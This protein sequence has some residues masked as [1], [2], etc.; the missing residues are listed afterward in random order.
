MSTHAAEKVRTSRVSSTSER[1]SSHGTST[2]P[3]AAA[4]RAS[5]GS[6][7]SHARHS[8]P[9][10]GYTPQHNAD[11]PAA[12]KGKGSDDKSAQ[13]TVDGWK[14]GRNDCLERV[15]QNQGYSLKEIYAKGADGK[16][17]MQSIA[18]QNGLSDPNKI[19]D[20]SK[21]NI[22]RKAGTVSAE[23][24]KPGQTVTR[25]AQD[26]SGTMAVTASRDPEHNAKTVQTD[27]KTAAPVQS[28]TTVQEGG[29]VNGT[30]SST[31][32]GLVSNV[33]GENKSGDATTDVK[34]VANGSG[35]ATTI[36]DSDARKNLSGMVDQ[37]GLY[38][39]NNGTG[40]GVETGLSHG[41]Q[42]KLESAGSWLDQHINPWG[43][44][45]DAPKEFTDASK[46]EHVKRPD[47]SISVSADGPEGRK[48]EWNREADG[49]FQRNLRA[50]NN[51]LFGG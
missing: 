22:P 45:T 11:E 4:N 30:V 47:G 19:A 38:A 20:A 28:S 43:P 33:H 17:L 27:T 16:T 34:T 21:L 35:T 2:A 25:E 40:G 39:V 12:P 32:Q 50:L 26:A 36:S 7:T 3:S 10:D 24:L 29:A 51:M 8:E 23:G 1:T 15:L 5:G 37:N 42:S 46:I 41:P 13:V 9:G 14:K 18:A 6:T 49:F 31:P 44:K 48:T